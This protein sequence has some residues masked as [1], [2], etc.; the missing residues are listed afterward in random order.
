[1]Q[2]GGG[3]KNF[4]EYIGEDIFC[5]DNN[6]YS[7]IHTW[8]SAAIIKNNEWLKHSFKYMLESNPKDMEQSEKDY[9]SKMLLSYYQESYNIMTKGKK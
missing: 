6:S 5:K 3:H 8:G 1:M 7:V 2:L 9:L 4:D